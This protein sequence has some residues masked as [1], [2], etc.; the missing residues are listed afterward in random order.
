MQILAWVAGLLC[1]STVLVDA[2]QTIVLPRRPRGRF[3][4]TRIFYLVTWTPWSAFTRRIQQRRVRETFYSIYGPGSLLMLLGVWA[5][6][7]LTGFALIY[8]ALGSPFHDI[9]TIARAT[10]WRLDLYV[11]GTTLFTLGLGDVVPRTL[12]V[13][14]LMVMESGTGLGFVALVVGYLPV[15]YQAFARREVA[16]ALLD[17]RAGSPPTA[18]ELLRRHS[19]GAAGNHKDGEAA[20]IVLLEEWERWSADLLESHISYSLLCY[21]RSQHDNQSWLSAVVAMLDACALLIANVQD[22]SARQAQLT[23]AMARHALVD[24]AQVF[25][26]APFQPSACEDRLAGGQFEAMCEQL[27]KAGVKLRT[28]EEALERLRELRELYEPHACALSAYLG[29]DLPRW[30]PAPKARDS[31]QTVAHPRTAAEII[32]SGNAHVASSHEDDH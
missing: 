7:I 19:F 13:R 28:D 5:L 8:Y 6:L 12:A 31:W 1:L 16:I 17:A 30:V 25:G 23:F 11:S 21:Y 29:I 3:R 24:L 15:V 4:M 18:A 22:V 20:L 32:Q 9:T 14:V 10:P 2:F 27:Q 26:R